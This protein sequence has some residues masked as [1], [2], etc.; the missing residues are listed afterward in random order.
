MLTYPR[1]ASVCRQR[2]TAARG[3]PVRWLI[4]AIDTFLRCWENARMT[5]SPRASDVM[6]FGSPSAASTVDAPA[7]RCARVADLAGVV[8]GLAAIW[9]TRGEATKYSLARESVDR[10]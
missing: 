9:G 7:T 3:M 1:R 10:P 2:R 6:K 5:A 4:S 8:C